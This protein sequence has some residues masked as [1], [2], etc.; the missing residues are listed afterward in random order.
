MVLIRPMENVMLVLTQIA[1]SVLFVGVLDAIKA[2]IWVELS[3]SHVLLI[4]LAVDVD[5]SVKDV[6]M[7]MD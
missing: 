7:A 3:V 5:R 1:I 6:R 2:T 4:V